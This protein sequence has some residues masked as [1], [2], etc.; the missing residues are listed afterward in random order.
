M[1]K[2]PKLYA[3]IDVETTGGNAQYHKI[4]EIAIRIF[5]GKK[6]IKT[7]DTLINPERMI[8]LGITKLTGIDDEMLKNAPTFKE[9]ADAIDRVTADCI[10]VAHNANFDYSF[11]RK[12]YRDLNRKFSRKKLCTVRLSRKIFPGL[13]SYSLGRLAIHFNSQ[14]VNRHR[15]GGDADFMVELFSELLINDKENHIEFAL[16]QRSRES[17]MPPNLP[18][19]KF[20]Q[21]PEKLGI[22]IFKDELDKVLY[23]GKAKNIKERVATHFGG[24]TNTN[25]R[26]MFI[27]KIYDVDFQLCENEMMAYL[28]EAHH[29]KQHWPPF[30]RSLKVIN[31]NVGI[32]HYEDQ[33]G[34]GRLAIARAGKK[35]H[36]LTSFR[37]QHQARLFL[38]KLVKQHNLC[39]K[40]LSL[41]ESAGGC[42]EYF[43]TSECLGTCSKLES[44]F[45]YNTRLQKAINEIM[46]QTHTFGIL[47]KSVMHDN[48]FS[49][50][51]IEKGR[52][53]GYGYINSSQK[54]NLKEL[55]QAKTH[56]QYAYDDQD[57]RGIIENYIKKHKARVQ[58]VAFSL[59]KAG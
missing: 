57:V 50:V 16:N 6:V 55:E 19:E 10:V 58:L 48:L 46:N 53:L 45:S 49:L 47:E 37:Y 38:L 35:D 11:I 29:I 39:P 28:K 21:L 23:V 43:G 44:A 41:Q 22:Y 8:P 56:I 18:R 36:P 59:K 14:I 30:N 7:Y 13:R 33:N 26:D 9:V 20:D 40:F 54:E 25:S 42:D 24:N 51:V 15:A 17:L 27:K 5:D 34:Y 12:E 32:Y 52:Y 2:K 31:L 1:A 3:I 4:T